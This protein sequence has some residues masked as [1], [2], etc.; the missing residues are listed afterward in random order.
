MISLT[1][2]LAAWSGQTFGQAAS[3]GDLYRRLIGE[4]E[5][6]QD[7]IAYWLDKTHDE[8]DS[9]KLL[10][11]RKL[12]EIGSRT[13]LARLEEL[14]SYKPRY[15]DLWNVPSEARQSIARIMSGPVIKEAR[16]AVGER[17]CELLDELRASRS[18]WVRDE[19]LRIL[20]ERTT[21]LP[22]A[23]FLVRTL[24][25]N[26]SDQHV[27]GRLTQYIDKYG[28]EMLPL[29]LDGIADGDP[30][31]AAS[32][33]GL[34]SARR[35]PETLPYLLQCLYADREHDIYARV[36][37]AAAQAIADSYASEA[38]PALDWILRGKNQRAKHA[39]KVCLR[40]IGTKDAIPVLQRGLAA[41]QRREKPDEVLVKEL[42]A[43]IKKI[44]GG[45][46]TRSARGKDR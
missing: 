5:Q 29:L 3:E 44:E 39:A 1:V 37:D 20:L 17:F 28:K 41:E 24:V 36:R 14:L 18:M 4:A 8:S 38:L 35:W 25:M 45:E 30:A 22:K 7:K 15:Y 11:V 43:A 13:A 9:V 19:A 6:A 34:L 2:A 33:I 12:G 27:A 46:G 23:A 16:S 31:T 40:F 21:L 26:S 42:S 10:A 32:C